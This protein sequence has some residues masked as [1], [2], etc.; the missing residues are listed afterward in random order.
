MMKM[1]RSC[2]NIYTWWPTALQQGF[3]LHQHLRRN[4]PASCFA[5]LYLKVG[6]EGFSKIYITCTSHYNAIIV[7]SQITL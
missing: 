4:L 6:S 3:R 2:N 1:T 5:T 7:S